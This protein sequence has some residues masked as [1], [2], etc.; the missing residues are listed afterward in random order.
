MLQV[1]KVHA[2]NPTLVLA[3]CTVFAHLALS[4]PALNTFNKVAIA[5]ANGVQVFP[6]RI[7]PRSLP[8]NLV[9]AN[10]LVIAVT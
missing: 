7:R 4:Q 1:L 10:P 5:W 3:S 8:N 9:K 2:T 6:A